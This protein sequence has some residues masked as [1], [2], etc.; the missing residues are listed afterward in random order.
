[1]SKLSKLSRNRRTE[2]QKRRA[3]EQPAR[4]LANRKRKREK[5]MKNHPN[6]KQTE[7]VL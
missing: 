1:M 2:N 3:S 5:H 4:T 7:A 6:D